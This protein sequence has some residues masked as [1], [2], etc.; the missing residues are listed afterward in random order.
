MFFREDIK[1]VVIFTV[2]VTFQ[3]VSFDLFKVLRGHDNGVRKAA[4]LCLMVMFNGN[5]YS[6]NLSCC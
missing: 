1:K 3:D 2:G 6:G 4:M 5:V